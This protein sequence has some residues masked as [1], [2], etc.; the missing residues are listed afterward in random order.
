M[1][2]FATPSNCAR[3]SALIVPA[4]RAWLACVH[5]LHRRGHIRERRLAV[6]LR[7]RIDGRAPLPEQA[8]AR[9]PSS[10]APAPCHR[11]SGCCRCCP[12]STSPARPRP[13]HWPS[14]S[15]GSSPHSAPAP[16][17]RRA[18][19]DTAPAA[20]ASS[21]PSCSRSSGTG[22]S[23][24]SASRRCTPPRGVIAR[25][26]EPAVEQ[27]QRSVDRAL[28][29]RRTF[30]S[31]LPCERCSAGIAHRALLHSAPLV[32]DVTEKTSTDPCP[33]KRKSN[34]GR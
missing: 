26:C 15:S 11:P 28:D 8:P 21:S 5:R 13:V 19:R 4:A 22:T 34:S 9:H 27:A 3:S 6:R 29:R 23:R 25:R 33:T 20:T 2:A 14:P 24:S 18:S 7:G 10:P 31:H 32:T 30:Q 17:W 1:R 12:A 16:R